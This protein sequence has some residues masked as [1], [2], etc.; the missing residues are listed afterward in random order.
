MVPLPMTTL[1]LLD[2][3][4]H[5]PLASKTSVTARDSAELFVSLLLLMPDSIHGTHKSPSTFAI[6]LG[7]R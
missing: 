3:P 1:R 7:D 2:T 5:Q 6:N 4:C